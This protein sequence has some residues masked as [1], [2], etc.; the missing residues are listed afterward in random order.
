MSS[1]RA[2]A[3]AAPR[4]RY[5]PIAAETLSVMYVALGIFALCALARFP[6]FL[7]RLLSGTRA[8]EMG[9]GI[10]FGVRKRGDWT[11]V[12]YELAAEGQGTGNAEKGD[13]TLRCKVIIEGPFVSDPERRARNVLIA[14]WTRTDAHTVLFMS[15]PCGRRQR[16]R[17]PYQRFCIPVIRFRPTRLAFSRTWSTKRT[18]KLLGTPLS[19]SSG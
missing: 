10:W 9:K 3:R 2:G 13:K 4:P 17:E 15:N 5:A 16:Y 14:G 7:A 12:L 18:R 6:R 8:G 11:R 1:G 19:P